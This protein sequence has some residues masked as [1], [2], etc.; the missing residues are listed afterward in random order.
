LKTVKPSAVTLIRVAFDLSS[1]T[2]KRKMQAWHL[3]IPA[4]LALGVLIDTIS[5][6]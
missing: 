3:A 1:L 6:M 5:K 4:F 2:C